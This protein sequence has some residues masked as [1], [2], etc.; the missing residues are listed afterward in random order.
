MSSKQKLFSFIWL[1]VEHSLS[2]LSNLVVTIVLAKQLGSHGFGELSAL[3]AYTFLFLPLFQAGLLGLLVKEVVTKDTD[4]FV[5]KNAAF[6]R[7]VFAVFAILCALCCAFFIPTIT[8]NIYLIVI[9]LVGQLGLIGTVSEQWFHA[10]KKVRIFSIIRVSLVATSALV[11]IVIA[12]RYQDITYLVFV[13]AIECLVLG[14]F[15]WLAFRLQN[16]NR[17]AKISLEYCTV[18]FHKAKW[19]ILSSAAATI[20]VKIDQVMVISIL[21]AEQNGIYAVAAKIAEAAF[22]LPT[23]II[24]VLFPYLLEKKSQSQKQY[25]NDVLKYFSIL[26]YLSLFICMCCLIL[27]PFVI[28]FIFGKEYLMSVG[29]L[30]I[31]IFSVVFVYMRTLVSRLIIAENLLPLSLISHAVGAVFN[32]FFNVLLIPQLGIQGAAYATLIAYFT[33]AFMVFF[34]FKK[35]RWFALSMLSSPIYFLRKPLNLTP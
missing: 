23:V 33:G 16:V 24:N 21:G 20:Y 25:R 31:Y 27:S 35:S 9:L 6:L 13:Y 34:F 18:L 14:V 28:P 29:V 19:L 10:R 2:L 30:N 4:Y 32:V 17:S 22:F 26:F 11:K 8:H 12:I 5:V 7:F 3:L 15:S 1:F